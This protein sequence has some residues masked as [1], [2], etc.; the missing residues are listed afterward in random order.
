MTW[1]SCWDTFKKRPENNKDHSKVFFIDLTQAL[2]PVNRVCLWFPLNS[3]GCPP[4]LGSLL[5]QLHVCMQAQ[6]AWATS[7]ETRLQ[8]RKVSNTDACFAPT[9]FTIYLTAVVELKF[10]ASMWRRLHEDNI[11]WQA[12]QP[13]ETNPKQKSQNLECK[14]FSTLRTP[15]YIV[16]QWSILRKE[17]L[18]DL[19]QLRKVLV[20]QSIL[21]KLRWFTNHRQANLTTYPTLHWMDRTLNDVQHYI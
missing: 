20:Y 14:I 16:W 8:G 19:M 15:H 7:R 18:R 21:L 9:L 17:C 13:Q 6:P 2:D 1:F 4:R 5:Q 12:V 3:L 10:A 11:W